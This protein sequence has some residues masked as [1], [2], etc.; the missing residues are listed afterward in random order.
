[1]PCCLALRIRLSPYGCLHQAR[2]LGPAGLL[3]GCCPASGSGGEVGAID[4][5]AR[6]GCE[7]R[8]QGSVPRNGGPGAGDWSACTPRSRSPAILWFLSNRLERNVPAKRRIPPPRWAH[9][10][11]PYTGAAYRGAREA[12][13]PERG[14]SKKEYNIR[15]LKN[16]EIYDIKIKITYF[17]IFEETVIEIE[18]LALR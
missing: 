8:L 5:T 3:S 15:Y 10:M 4:C 17:F 1:M 16:I 18:I 12:R 7:E 6:A 11:R 9:T 2:F 14:G 13:R